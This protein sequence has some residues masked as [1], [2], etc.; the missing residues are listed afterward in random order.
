VCAI[1]AAQLGQDVVVVDA[2][3]YGGTCLAKGCIPSKALIH[4][5][6]VYAGMRAAHDAEDMGIRLEAAPSLDMAGFQR[7]KNSVVEKLESGVEFLLRKHEVRALRGWARFE[8][9]KTCS[10]ETDDGRIAVRAKHVVLATGS[11][12][13][14][15]PGIPFSGRVLDSTAA[16]DLDRV[17]ERLLLV[18]AGYIGLELGIAFSRL[19][20]HVTLVEA[21][22]H[23]LPGF[24]E[25]LSRP[26]A[27]WMEARGIEVHLAA[28]IDLLSEHATGVEAT[29]TDARGTARVAAD[30]A[31]INVGR[32]PAYED[33]GF[34][35]LCLETSDNFIEIDERC[36]TSMRDVWAIGDVTGQPQLAHRASAQGR[37]VAELIC[38]LR[39]ETAPV[40]IPAVCFTEPEV[41][42][43]GLNPAQ[44][45]SAYESVGVSKY[46]FSGVGKALAM[47][48]P[49]DGTFLRIVYRADTHR[50]LGVQAVGAKVSE[51][52]N[53]FALALEMG[54]A[55]EDVAETIHA[56]P[57]LGEAFMEAAQ[58]ALDGKRA[59]VR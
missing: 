59:G 14:E 7:W 23:I 28:S 31:L 56:H 46:P 4:M 52:A 54:A 15:L 36:R 58:H 17:P 10:V 21:Q 38:G 13:R 24:D 27:R 44:A 3:R 55:L 41:I 33:C 11:S 1:R 5:A 51:L 9:G 8:D 57:T 50:I 25:E 18:G 22:D 48:L 30:Y 32:V 20:S 42:S 47:N 37:M 35:N 19:G 6:G 43:V 2:N 12:P 45:R 39:A 49:T 34:E 16:L 53:S 40:A 26:I 29:I